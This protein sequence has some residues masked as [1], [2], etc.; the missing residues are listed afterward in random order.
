MHESPPRPGT[1]DG[2]GPL[3]ALEL[4][5]LSALL[6]G[7]GE[8][9]ATLRAQLA[10]ASVISR[11][12]SGV[13]FMTR[14]AVPDEAPAIATAAAPRLVPLMARHPQLSEPAEFVLQLR[15]GRLASLEAFC[16]AGG[17]PADADRFQVV[18]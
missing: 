11:S 7:E 13:G 2:P 8:P 1:M 5:V 10:G 16:F 9:L 14:F 6:R 15:D 17:W 12:H 3:S 4:N 18:P